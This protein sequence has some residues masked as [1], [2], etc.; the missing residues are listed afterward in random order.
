MLSRLLLVCAMAAMTWPVAAAHTPGRAVEPFSPR[1]QPGDYVWRPEVS[2]AGPVVVWIRLDQQT[3]YVFRNGVRIGRSTI[4]SGRPGHRTPTG[5]FTV[6]E[7]QVQHVSTLYRG[8]QMPYMQRLTWR[9]VALHAG[10]LP[11]RPDSH[12]CIRLP[13]AFAQ[14]LYAVTGKGTT[15]LISA[16]EAKAGV[17]TRP[18]L[19]FQPGGE[20]LTAG[21]FQWQPEKAPAGPLT[22][23]V[24]TADG[25]VRVF[26]GGVQIGRAAFAKGRAGPGGVHVFTA[27]D[28]READ[29][30][31]AWLAT[32]SL[33]RGRAP[34]LSDLAREIQLPEAFR[35]QLRDAITA[36]TTLVVTD[37]PLVPRAV[38]APRNLLESERA[39]RRRR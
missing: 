23:V 33:G 21:T 38:E 35:S 34:A 11:G 25:E 2:P 8:A 13:Y 4:S 6:L 10:Y 31:R 22:L 28:R 27:L 32:G 15:V 1:L 18:G 3:L 30:R 14:K 24:S 29:G 17:S 16:G 12:G 5:A 37:R 20:P 39:P 26:R 19:L 7:K 36:G 9:G